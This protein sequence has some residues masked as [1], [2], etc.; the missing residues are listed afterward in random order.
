M[1]ICYSLFCFEKKKNRLFP[2][3]EGGYI[4]PI[5]EKKNKIFTLMYY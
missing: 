3:V 4:S 2:K 1:E 5:E